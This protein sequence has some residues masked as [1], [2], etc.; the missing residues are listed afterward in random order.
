MFFISSRNVPLYNGVLEY[1]RR[2]GLIQSWFLDKPQRW[3]KTKIEFWFWNHTTFKNAAALGT[4][5]PNPKESQG[6]QSNNCQT[7]GR[8][9]DE[10]HMHLATEGESVGG[11]KTNIAICNHVATC[12]QDLYVA[13]SFGLYMFCILL[14]SSLYRIVLSIKAFPPADTHPRLPGSH[15]ILTVTDTH[16]SWRLQLNHFWKDSSVNS[17]HRSW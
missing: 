9:G 6:F 12:Y 1:V 2:M 16:L 14:V 10:K 7:S 8:R 5:D 13:Q 11:I 15:S 17:G 4:N 3:P